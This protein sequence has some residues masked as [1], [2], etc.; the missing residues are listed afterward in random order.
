MPIFETI[1]VLLLGA[2]ALTAI[3]KRLSIPYPTLLALGGACVTLLP[4]DRTLRLD[5]PPELILTLFVA[6]ILLDAAH[7]TSLRDLRANWR[8]VLSLVLIAVGLTTI[9]VA[10]IASQLFPDMPWAAAV[11]LGALLAPPD[12]VAAMT[13]LRHANPPHRIRTVLEGESLL[14]NASALLL[15]KL[16]VGAV[17]AGSFSITDALPTFGLVV[18]GSVVAGWILARLAG[19]VL[20]RVRDIPTS[21]ILQFV[22]TFGVWL[23]AEHFGLSGIVTIVVFGLVAARYTTLPARQRISTFAI[24]ES[25]TFVLNVLAF[26]LIG[27]Q[28]RPILE[29][30]DGQSL[31]FLGAALI[32]LVVVIAVRLIWVML[33]N[34]IT[35]QKHISDNN[36]P[37]MPPLTAKAGLVIAWSGMRGIVTLAAAMAIPEPFPYRD[38]IQLT[39]FVVVLGTLVIQGTTLRPLVMFLR[40]PKDDTVEAEINY[41]RGAALQAA[42]EELEH[43][44]TEAAQR[45][46]FEYNNM[47]IQA[48]NAE[49]PHDSDENA[50]RRK[51]VTSV[52]S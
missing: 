33:A 41:A 20:A 29:A 46:K 7:D 35:R 38:F 18:V 8:P 5:M 17:V 15:Y 13:V 11:A 9:V 16:A 51:V 22:L 25:A 44:E 2:T 4:V 26:T 27:L 39:A 36:E 24:W 47:L 45:L 49:D 40:L 42:A 3:A 6:P 19:Q 28:M 48:C 32:I 30:L 43:N 31:R 50:L 12:A 1:L 14:N 37:A 10:F 34:L 52:A 23:L 21:V